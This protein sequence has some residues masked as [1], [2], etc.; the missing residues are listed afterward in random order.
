MKNRILLILLA[1]IMSISFIPLA[2]AGTPDGE[3]P[4][5]ETVCDEWE[6]ATTAYGLCIA[7]CEA[8]DC[9]LD[10]DTASCQ[11]LLRNFY[12]LETGLPYFP[13][14]D[15]CPNDP[16]K[17]ID[18]DEICGD[19]DN[20]PAISNPDQSD[21]D[22]DLAG[23]VCDSCPSDPDD[24]IDGDSICGDADNCPNLP[25]LDQA[26]ADDNGIGDACEDNYPEL[27]NI[28]RA[29]DSVSLSIN[30]DAPTPVEFAEASI[31]WGWSDDAHSCLENPSLQN[32]GWR[33]R[34][35][36][37]TE[38]TEFSV[39][40]GGGVSQGTV[41]IDT[42]QIDGIGPFEL[43]FTITDCIG[44]MTDSA[45][46]YIS[47][48]MC[49]ENPYYDADSD[50]VGNACDNCRYDENA[51]QS[52]VDGDGIG[53]VCDNCP[54]DPDNDIDS[55]GVCADADNCPD[56][57]N[58]DQADA[59]GDGIGDA[60]DICPN[61]PENDIDGD[62][63]CGD[64]DNCPVV[65][66]PDQ[67]DMDGDLSGD[68]CDICPN[69]PEN[70]IDGDGICSDADNCPDLANAGQVDNDGNGIGDAC[71]DNY[72]NLTSIIRAADS[73]PLSINPEAPTPVEYAETAILWSWFDDAYSCPYNPMLQYLGW[74]YRGVGAT[75][76]V[77]LSVGD[78]TGI[79][80]G[81]GGGTWYPY[82]WADT[83]VID[84][85]QMYGTGPFEFQVTI[86]DCIGQTT[87]SPVFYI[88][89]DMCPENPY[90]DAD[91]DGVGD[92]CDNCPDDDN[93][94]QSD[95]DGDGIGDAC[96]VCPNDADNDLGGDGVCSDAD[97]CPDVDNP[98]QA[99][100]DGD[101]VGDACDVCPN[102]ADND[103]DGDGVCGDADNCPDVSN[104]DQADADGNGIGDACDFVDN[105]PEIS[106]VIRVGDNAPLSTDVAAPTEVAAS[107]QTILW[108]WA[109]DAASCTE[110]PEL[111]YLGWRYRGVG[112]TEWIDFSIVPGGEGGGQW[113][114]YG[115]A[116]TVE[117]DTSQIAGYG[118]FEFQVVIIDCIGQMTESAVFYITIAQP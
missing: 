47:I 62:G 44:Q 109:D 101:G 5:E 104:P 111:Q 25:N 86:T 31:M 88:N 24:D 21:L 118:P 82:A 116:D 15:P 80:T 97:N 50:G 53:D 19:V 35:V 30:P 1:I 54:N 13:C 61:D 17:D 75:E 68:V 95:A 92:V 79:S 114:P 64:V 71:E 12:K 105:P 84:T 59:D 10:P 20:C 65:N 96:D 38:W 33:Y 67:S 106:N 34:S 117:I 14:E 108:N 90:Y 89:I 41:V 115:W 93:A 73:V 16:D 76:W 49:P 42:S 37:A 66:N 46:F 58:P 11:A 51:D 29:A 9:D 83:V 113:W 52:D 22:G 2:I 7:Y 107:V 45:L 77:E 57:D 4:A 43:Q 99:D 94:D 74:R 81:E 39:G 8:K 3:T 91:S 28:I 56:I 103:L 102:D 32:L 110:N 6:G 27:L 63:I 70:D 36:W 100:A 23:D 85:T 87:N 26:D 40:D 98:D 69:D 55:D 112:E 78:G 18:G 72:P 60:C 48:D